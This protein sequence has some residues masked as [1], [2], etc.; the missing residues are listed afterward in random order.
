MEYGSISLMVE[1]ITADQCYNIYR[2][3]YTMPV[4]VKAG[5]IIPMSENVGDIGNP[6]NM[7]IQVFPC[8]DNSFLLYEDDGVT[9]NYENGE[10][11]K[12][13]FELQWSEKA[14]VYYS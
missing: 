12:T 5:G 1:D 6:K 11:V 8:A 3:I 9:M 10:C 4:L 2:D 14:K 13:I 7:T